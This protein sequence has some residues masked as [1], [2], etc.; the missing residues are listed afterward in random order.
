MELR[1]QGISVVF[2]SGEMEQVKKI[3]TSLL[4][5][6]NTPEWVRWVAEYLLDKA[7]N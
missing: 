6:P 2:F 5:A 3:L 4:D 1:A 7:K